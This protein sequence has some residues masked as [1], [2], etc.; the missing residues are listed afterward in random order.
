MHIPEIDIFSDIEHELEL[1][2]NDINW[3]FAFVYALV[4]YGIKHKDE[5]TWYNHM[6][7]EPPLSYYKVWVAGFA[8][9]FMFVLFE[10]LSVGGLH[11][12]YISQLMR[13]WIIVIVFNAVILD[14]IKIIENQGK[15]DNE[16]HK[17]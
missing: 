4:L 10:W 8:V 1:F 2:W 14:K 11:S 3:T 5:F 13:S 9:G 6:F 16:K 17:E 12:V 15:K 7:A